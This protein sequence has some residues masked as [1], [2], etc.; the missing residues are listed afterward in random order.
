[1]IEF[2]GLK[3]RGQIGL[4]QDVESFHHPIELHSGE[5]LT[6]GFLITKEEEVADRDVNTFDLK[7]R[8]FS[9]QYLILMGFAG[10]SMKLNGG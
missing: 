3:A 1:M 10:S 7:H 6:V 5:H 8:L 2:V 4:L 9:H